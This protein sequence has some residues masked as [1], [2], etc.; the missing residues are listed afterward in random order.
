MDDPYHVLGLPSSASAEDIRKAYRSYARR[1]HPDAGGSAAEFARL[2]VAYD[3]LG[4]ATKR[5]QWDETGRVDGAEDPDANALQV[6][7]QV[8]QIVLAQDDEPQGDIMSAITQHLTNEMRKPQDQI[9][10]LERALKRSKKLTDALVASSDEAKVK[11]RI[12]RVISWHV[13]QIEQ[14]LRQAK[15]QLKTLERAKEICSEWGLELPADSPIYH[16]VNGIDHQV[17]VPR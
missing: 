13:T 15:I 6:I 7:S 12:P 16:F 5:K 8:F 1:L 4:D 3:I 14:T 9:E 17:F 10:K 2:Q 11:A